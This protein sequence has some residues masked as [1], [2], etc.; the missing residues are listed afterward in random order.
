MCVPWDP[1]RRRLDGA[2]SN[3][4]VKIEKL[5]SEKQKKI[6]KVSENGHT[7]MD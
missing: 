6:I 5:K 2:D 3:E 4:W 1:K 7:L